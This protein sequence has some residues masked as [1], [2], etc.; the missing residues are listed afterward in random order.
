M[1]WKTGGTGTSLS[2]SL[3]RTG[4]IAEGGRTKNYG[5]VVAARDRTLELFPEVSKK[6]EV[7]GITPTPLLKTASLAAECSANAGS[8]QLWMALHF[9]ALSFEVL[10]LAHSRTRPL[11]VIEVREDKQHVA[12]C[13]RSAAGKGI[14][15]GMSVNAAYALAETLDVHE[16]HPGKEQVCLERLALQAGRFTSRVSIASPDALLLEIGGSRRLFGGLQSLCNRLTREI[17]NRNVLSVAPL[18]PAAL[19]LARAGLRKKVIQ[20]AGLRSALAD[21][22]LGVTRWPEETLQLLSG[23]GVHSL[24]ECLRLPR[25][26]LA[27]R[28]GANLL[29]ELEQATGGAMEVRSDHRPQ[30]RFRTTVRPEEEINETGRLNEELQSPLQ[31]LIDFLARRQAAIQ[32]LELSLFHRRRPVTRKIL[33][34]AAPFHEMNILRSMVQEHLV[35]L[36]LPAPVCRFGLRSGRLFPVEANSRSMPF[37]RRG[38]LFRQSEPPVTAALFDKLRA[39]LGEAGVYRLQ[40][41]ADHRPEK[42]AAREKDLLRNTVRALPAGP[43]RARPLWLLE[44]PEV[45]H[46][47]K[48]W[49]QYR[50]FLEI[51]QG[52]ERIESGWWD[53]ADVA[54]DYYVARDTAGLR[55]WVYRDRCPPHGWFLHGFF[56]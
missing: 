42:A 54:R 20:P 29:L 9:P 26:G 22:P 40:A 41:V 4:S 53:G 5:V 10:G 3:V 30:Q 13:N 44:F 34:F 56:G 39:K 55:L 48:G 45:L 25:D 46:E 19:W 31:K 14:A 8:R 38:E 27:R 15:I 33:R 18:P 50:G 36:Q 32:A 7:L 6:A 12:A 1:P 52:P 16:R 17:K 47:R 2:G 49:P 43:G 23:M 28:I 21:V 24:G 11:I 51:E 35:H 37:N